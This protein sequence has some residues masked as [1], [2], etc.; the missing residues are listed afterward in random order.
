MHSNGFAAEAPPVG[1]PARL[2][3]DVAELDR[4]EHRARLGAG[5]NRHAKAI[6]P[7]RN[8]ETSWLNRSARSHCIQWPVREVMTSSAL[9]ITLSSIGPPAGRLTLSSRP[10]STRV[11]MVSSL[12]RLS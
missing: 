11:G 3:D 1:E 2:D 12:R 5:P 4:A 6:R 9:G 8:S 10:H 7:E